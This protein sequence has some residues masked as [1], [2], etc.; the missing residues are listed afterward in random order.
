MLTDDSIQSM[1]GKARAESLSDE[2]RAEIAKK[3]AEARWGMPVE[4]HAG[5]LDIGGIKILCHVL[6]DGTRLVSQEGV[7]RGL[8]RR[9]RPK[10]KHEENRGLQLPVFLQA[11]NLEPFVPQVDMD[12]F[13]PI[14][15]KRR[16]GG[17]YS[18]GYRAEVLPKA[19]NVFLDAKEAGA[20]VASQLATAERCKILSRGLSEV[21][22]IALVDEA[23]GY[24]EVRDRLALQ[25]ILEKFISKELLKWAKRF[26]DDFYKE[27]FRLKSW[28][29]QGMKIN[30]P[31]VVGHYTNDII[32]D[33][34]APGV[35]DELRQINPPDEAG[36]RK[37]KHHQWLTKDV[38][39][40]KLRDH[41][42]G[43]LALMRASQSWDQ[44]K[45]MIDRAFPKMNT[46]M[47][48][49]FSADEDAV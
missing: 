27:M 13:K 17:P 36:H 48:L 24:Q 9:G 1:G 5:E 44:F 33:R 18:V 21:G 29:W 4:T 35:L 43:V 31:S 25:K 49:P 34:L 12:V 47:M 46:T 15:F 3:A 6:S 42:S 45:R 2:E 14:R 30:R 23:T 16:L 8:G 22:I 19:C 38:G 7:N 32:Y 41:L 10:A 40:P 39:H 11:N 37:H 26:P 28:Q 20:L